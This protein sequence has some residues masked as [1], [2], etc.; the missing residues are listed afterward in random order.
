MRSVLVSLLLALT[1]F[2]LVAIL[3]APLGVLSLLRALV[4]LFGA[5]CLVAAVLLSARSLDGVTTGA[6]RAREH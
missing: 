6:L 2:T 1:S 4:F 5:A 3:P